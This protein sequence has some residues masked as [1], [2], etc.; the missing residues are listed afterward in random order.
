MPERDDLLA[1][2]TD[3]RTNFLYTVAELDDAG[4]VPGRRSAS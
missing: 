4:A 2:V 1:L 3:Q